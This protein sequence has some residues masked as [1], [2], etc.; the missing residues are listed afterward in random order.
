VDD[1]EDIL[2][3]AVGVRLVFDQLQLL[4]VLVRG[5]EQPLARA[6]EEREGQQVVAVDQA[7]VRRSLPC[8]ATPG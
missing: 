1:V 2:L 3:Q 6:E 8:R 4:G 5:A 7:G